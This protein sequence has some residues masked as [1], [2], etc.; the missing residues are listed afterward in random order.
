[1]IFSLIQFPAFSAKWKA[2]RLTDRDL[3]KLE[4]QLMAR[5]DAGPV[6][7]GTGGLRKVRFAPPTWHTGKSG[8][9]RVCYSVFRQ[10]GRIYLV[11]FFAKNESDN[12]TPAERKAI[13]SLLEQLADALA[14]GEEP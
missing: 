7:K 6:M 3:Q 9:A 8:A 4:E 14:M 1:M 2:F 5:P 11:T 13:K 12:L 10:Y